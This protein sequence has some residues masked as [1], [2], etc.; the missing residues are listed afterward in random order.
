[1]ENYD[2]IVVGG[3]ISGLTSAAY[4]ARAG[5]NVILFEKNDKCGGLVN[6]FTK[7]GFLF[8]GGVRALESAGIILPML[9]E[10]EIELE[11]VKSPVSLGIENEIIHINSEESLSDYAALLRKFYPD[12][13]NEIENVISVIKKITKDM[14]VLYGVDN[15]LFMNFLKDKVYFVKVYLPWLFKFLLTLRRINKM[16]MPVE[17]LLGKMVKN[18][19]LN[20]IISQHFFKSTPAFFAMSYF[21]LYQD[22][23][24]PRGGVGKLAEAVQKKIQEFG[25]KVKTGT[26]I[27]KVLSAS[28]TLMDKEGNSYKYN[29]LIWAA[30]LKKLY[31]ITTTENLPQEIAEKIESFRNELS[32]KHGTDSVFSLFIAVDEPPENFETITRG[33]FFYTPSKKGLGETNRSELK[34]IVQ[35]F[36]ETSKEKIL[37][38]LDKYCELNT[39]EISIPVLKDPRAAPE[40]KTGLI[41]SI[42]FG[43]ELVK[44]IKEAGW[45]AEF[46]ENVE[47]KM[48]EVLSRSVFPMLENKIIFKFS[49][50]P[51]SIES[52]V[53][54]SEGSIVGWS[55]EDP[56][57]VTS[58]MLKVNDSVKTFI[59]NVLQAGQ[60]TYSPS[61]VP[62][63][64]LTGK[65]AADKASEA[66]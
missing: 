44:K 60:W 51:L 55:F 3:G 52:I 17:E 65:L 54:S 19:S 1:M 56:I 10:L 25:G 7:D 29:D 48:I 62:M 38:W 12:S 36:S 18:N 30:D 6:S 13:E 57:P 14:E 22:Y 32:E 45:Y 15:P 59:P 42:L 40:G 58:S 63:C 43:Y 50:T 66:K 26:E 2:A 41:V 5:S 47:N 20:D 39:Y 23:F 49:A 27:E 8:D 11:T 16:K 9:K 33:H 46:K 35:H 4:L 31:S 24:Y 28:N 64:I 53:G 61:G 21:Y 37:E 34:N